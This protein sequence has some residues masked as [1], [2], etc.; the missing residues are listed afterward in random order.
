MAIWESESCVPGV[1]REESDERW[2]WRGRQ[3]GKPFRSHVVTWEK[4]ENID[5]FY[6]VM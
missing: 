3:A 1:Q 5:G 6:A 4:W 2:V